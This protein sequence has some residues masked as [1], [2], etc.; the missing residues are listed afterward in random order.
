MI[1]RMG[2]VEFQIMY[3]YCF[4]DVLQQEI[5]K[6]K[7]M[8]S[9][10]DNDKAME[11]I[12]KRI[13]SIAKFNAGIFPV[14]EDYLR[15]FA[16]TYFEAV[17]SADVMGAFGGNYEGEILKRLCK[18][19]LDVVE[20]YGLMPYKS[21]ICWTK[22]LKGKKVL[23]I[24]PLD[25]L[26]KKQYLNRE[27]LFKNADFLPEFELKTLKAINSAGYNEC[28]FSTWHEALEYMYEEIDKI[29]FDIA[30]IGAGAYGL[31]LASYVKKIGKIG[32]HLGGASQLLFGIKGFRW[33]KE[34][35]YN[36]YWKRPDDK[37]KPKG[38]KEIEGG[39]YW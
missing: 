11:L 27:K 29:D 9:I 28:E 7:I 15:K 10:D 38:F 25:E 3:T 12:N 18:K 17:K 35:I 34:G 5:E 24:H 21:E 16:K 39:C 26:I 14:N 37:D 30:I 22:E 31:P 20:L 1:S 33:D 4:N 2:I 32:I 6:V 36:E 23:V 13:K 8:Y 19:D